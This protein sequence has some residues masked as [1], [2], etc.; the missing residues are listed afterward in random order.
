MEQNRNKCE[1]VQIK[2]I[3]QPSKPVE[4]THGAQAGHNCPLEL[5]DSGSITDTGQA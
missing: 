2:Y 3:N 4:N 5:A 1:R